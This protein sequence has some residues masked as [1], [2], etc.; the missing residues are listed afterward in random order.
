MQTYEEIRAANRLAQRKYWK[1]KK[2]KQVKKDYV[3]S[4]REQINIYLRKRYKEKREELCAYNRKWGKEHNDSRRKWHRD[5]CKSN[6]T[7]HKAHIALWT[8]IR[9]GQLL[10]KQQCSMC[11]NNKRIE[12]HHPNYAQPLT[13]VWLC[14]QCHKRFHRYMRERKP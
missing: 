12:A 2:A 11:S 6:P 7:A 4:H 8:A 5:W 3:A 13:V 1:T 10:P 14:S 9:K